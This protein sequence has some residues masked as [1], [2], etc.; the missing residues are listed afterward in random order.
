MSIVMTKTCTNC[1][2]DGETFDLCP[3]CEGDGAV[4][5]LPRN[6]IEDEVEVDVDTP[7]AACIHC[8]GSGWIPKPCRVCRGEGS[9]KV[10]V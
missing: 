2:G 4:P 10:E 6:V 3:N 8:D 5:I 1:N 7:F 9:S